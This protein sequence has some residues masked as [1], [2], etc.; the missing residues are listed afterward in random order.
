MGASPRWKVYATGYKAACKEIE[1]AAALAAFYGP[2]TQ[3][4]DGHSPHRVIWVEGVTGHAAEYYDVVAVGAAGG[5][6]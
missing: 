2:G 5:A 4:R 1:A 6:S 3:I